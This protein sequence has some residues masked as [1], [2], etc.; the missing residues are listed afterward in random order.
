MDRRHFLK[1]AA[2]GSLSGAVAVP[3]LNLDWTNIST[4]HA[5]IDCLSRA[6]SAQPILNRDKIEAAIVQQALAESYPYPSVR[7]VASYTEAYDYLMQDDKLDLPLLKSIWRP[8]QQLGPLADFLLSDGY[9]D[10]IVYKVTQ[11]IGGDDG[12][13]SFDL[14]YVHRKCRTFE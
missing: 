4:G 10:D 7:W 9:P 5:F 6:G 14:E 8:D 2:L 3:C 13:S 12:F 11:A 1:F